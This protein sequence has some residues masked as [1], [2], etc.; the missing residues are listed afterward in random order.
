MSPTPPAN[1]ATYTV[2][3]VGFTDSTSAP[4][5]FVVPVTAVEYAAAP[6]RLPRIVTGRAGSAGH[7]LQ[8]AG[9]RRRRAVDDGRRRRLDRQGRSYRGRPQTART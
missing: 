1:E 7:G 9:H 4:A 2:P 5:E 6:T 3:F 8:Q